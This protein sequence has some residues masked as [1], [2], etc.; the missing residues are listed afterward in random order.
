MNKH[1][2]YIDSLSRATA[3][4]FTLKATSR[5]IAVMLVVADAEAELGGFTIAVAIDVII[6][7][8]E[9]SLN[10][11]DG[12]KGDRLNEFMKRMGHM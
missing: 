7:L 9:A 12:G 5:K 1:S 8:E 6:T 3:Q 10:G 2:K 4:I 11:L